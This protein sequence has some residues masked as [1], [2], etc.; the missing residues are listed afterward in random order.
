MTK[1][2]KAI[3][4]AILSVN[5][6][7][8]INVYV[9]LLRG[10]KNAKLTSYGL[11]TN[12][13]FGELK[14][15]SEVRI[16]EIISHLLTNHYLYQTNDKYMLL[17]VNESA[18]QI[19]ED[20]CSVLL[21]CAKEEPEKDN[22]NVGKKVFSQKVPLSEILTTKGLELFDALRSVRTEIAREEAV[23]PYIVFSDK[24]LVDMCIKVPFSKEEMLNVQGVGENKFEKYGS[25]FL[26]AIKNQT[27]EVKME[28][29]YETITQDIQLS[30]S[31]KVTRTSSAKEEFSLICSLVP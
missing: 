30:S 26:Q 23:P 19:L 14:E 25:R 3:V 21:K 13:H 18:K 16:K 24:T 20:K 12:S 29:T 5:Q 31:A 1:E 28:T 8:G 11:D 4:Q 22:T 7:Y 17:K 6:R 27:G 2:S 10:R 9:N 15:T